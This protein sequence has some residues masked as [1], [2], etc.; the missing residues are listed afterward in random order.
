[1]AASAVNFSFKLKAFLK[2]H[3]VVDLRYQALR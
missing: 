2:Q 3:L 1:L